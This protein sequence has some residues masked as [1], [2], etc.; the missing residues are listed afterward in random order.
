MLAL[1]VNDRPVPVAA[2]IENGRVL[3]P[4]RATANALGAS[5]WY[6]PARR[7][8]VVS[9]FS[10]RIA[11]TPR[12]IAN[13]SYVPLRFIAQS[14]GA[15]VGYDGGQHLVRITDTQT[16]QCIYSARTRIQSYDAPAGTAA[17]SNLWGCSDIR[18]GAVQFL[19]RRRQ[20]VLSG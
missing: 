3:L 5:V 15:S 11:I 16:A 18:S 9:R 20:F 12:I 10:Q 6:D 7:I 2:V 4:L 17:E 14:L 13:R 1:T 8:V 19:H